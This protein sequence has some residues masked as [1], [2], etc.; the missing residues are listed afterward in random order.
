MNNDGEMKGCENP[1]EIFSSFR[2]NGKSLH[3]EAHFSK[4]EEDEYPLAVFGKFAR[5]VFNGSE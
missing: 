3:I 4:A 1:R 5:L 2:E